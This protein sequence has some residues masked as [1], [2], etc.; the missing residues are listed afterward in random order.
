MMRVDRAGGL[1]RLSR[2]FTTSPAV[3]IVAS[4]VSLVAGALLGTL[5]DDTIKDAGAL[6]V[7]LAGLT[8][9]CLVAF[10]L[11]LGGVIT[12]NRDVAHQLEGL[13]RGLGQT[14]GY[15]L[16]EDLT[17]PTE[18]PVSA[19]VSAA[20][21]EI[22]VLDMVDSEGERPAHS[23]ESSVLTGFLEALMRRADSDPRVRYHRICQVREP[24]GPLLTA[25]GSYYEH[26]RGICARKSRGDNRFSLRAARLRYPFKFIMIDSRVVMLQLNRYDERDHREAWSELLFVNADPALVEAFQDIWTDVRDDHRTRALQVSDIRKVEEG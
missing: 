7:S 18:D 25:P 22:L 14:V 6:T 10:A 17:S 16:V 23:M 21:S 19:A 5:F 11:M 12:Q 26:V 15:Q 4:L 8:V 9:V 3:A 20:E 1:R 24:Q 13:R 2:V